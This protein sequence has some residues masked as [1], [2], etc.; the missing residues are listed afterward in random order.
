MRSPTSRRRSATAIQYADKRRHH[1]DRAAP[2]R[3]HHHAARR[4]RATRA[5]LS[6]GQQRLERTSRV[7]SCGGSVA[8]LSLRERVWP[9]GECGG[10]FG[11]RGGLER[12]VRVARGV[13][14]RYGHFC[15]KCHVGGHGALRVVVL[16]PRP[17]YLSVGMVWAFKPCAARTYTPTSCR[18]TR[19]PKTAICIATRVNAIREPNDR[20]LRFRNML[21]GIKTTQT[22]PMA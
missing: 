20:R 5:G 1:P 13:D 7:C 8:L 21:G 22:L 6:G 9:G 3:L 11:A 19:G 15:A 4:R 2:S 16:R 17:M 12:R 14:W 10:V 18:R